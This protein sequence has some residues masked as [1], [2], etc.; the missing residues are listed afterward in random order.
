MI[1]R[2]SVI[3]W[4]YMSAMPVAAHS[5]DIVCSITDPYKR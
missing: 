5:N 4:S 1:N 3:E 2:V